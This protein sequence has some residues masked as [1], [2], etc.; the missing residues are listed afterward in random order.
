MNRAVRHAIH[1]LNTQFNSEENLTCHWPELAFRK[2]VVKPNLH[3]C[4]NGNQSRGECIKKKL[5]EERKK[6]FP[7]QPNVLKNFLYFLVS[8]FPELKHHKIT[9]PQ[10]YSLP[11]QSGS[12]GVH[13]HFFISLF[14]KTVTNI[15]LAFQKASGLEYFL[16]KCQQ[17]NLL[18]VQKT[19]FLSNPGVDGGTVLWM[20]LQKGSE[21]QRETQLLQFLKESWREE[22]SIGGNRNNRKHLYSMVST[23]FCDHIVVSEC[24]KIPLWTRYF[25]FFHFVGMEVEKLN[26]LPNVSQ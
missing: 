23:C 18:I 6:S 2:S 19:H 4:F 13:K 5:K 21:P 1:S 7:S 10:Q 26:V 8:F 16:V 15:F 20:E 25:Y 11:A 12:A 22:F 14:Y 17:R 24:R 3:G 9:T